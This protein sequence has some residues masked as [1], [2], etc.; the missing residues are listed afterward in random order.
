M[1]TRLI[2]MIAGRD[3]E[4]GQRARSYAERHWGADTMVSRHLALFESLLA[5]QPRPGEARV[6]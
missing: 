3:P 1:A 2:E 4:L 6:P 5:D